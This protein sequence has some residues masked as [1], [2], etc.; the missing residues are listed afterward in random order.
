MTDPQLVGRGIFKFSFRLYNHRILRKV[1]KIGINLNVRH[2]PS[3]AMLKHI[4]I[5]QIGFSYNLQNV[6]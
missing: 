5:L 2:M 1:F 4:Q 6:S 3:V